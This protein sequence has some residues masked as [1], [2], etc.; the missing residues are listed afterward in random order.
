MIHNWEVVEY[1]DVELFPNVKITFMGWNSANFY[2][3]RS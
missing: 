1:L 3:N 2:Q